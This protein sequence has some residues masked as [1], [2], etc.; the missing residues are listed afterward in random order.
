MK[1]GWIGFLPNI[2]MDINSVFDH[3]ERTTE[4]SGRMWSLWGG[5]N[6][7]YI[8][9]TYDFRSDSDFLF[10]ISREM[11]FR[12]SD[13]EK[14]KVQIEE[15]VV[16]L[17]KNV[18][19]IPEEVDLRNK[20]IETTEKLE[21]QMKELHE[22]LEAEVGGVRQLIGTSEK[23]QDF[24]AFTTDIEH[25]KTTHVAKEIFHSE[26][27]RVDEKID[28]GLEALN[29]RIEDLKAIKFWSKRTLLEI[30]LAIMAVIATLYGAGVIKF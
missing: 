19:A 21:N 2:D 22:R 20:I 16:D 3:L 1:E 18:E 23:F 4:L 26:I 13:L 25:L 12:E 8:L 29:T 17:R 10:D 28:K 24:K 30:A 9:S 15:T 5:R 6:S 14:R 7:F 27:K 11:V